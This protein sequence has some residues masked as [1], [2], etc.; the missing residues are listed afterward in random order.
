MYEEPIMQKWKNK[1]INIW[2]SELLLYIF[3]VV[4]CS[5]FSINWQH[6]IHLNVY[7]VD[8]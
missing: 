7:A 2:I 8:I 4:V 6:I 5:V 3:I 1:C